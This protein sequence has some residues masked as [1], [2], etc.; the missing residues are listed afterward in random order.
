MPRG[1][2]SVS[3]AL[4]ALAIVLATI[5]TGAVAAAQPVD[6]PP[7]AAGPAADAVAATS[8]VVVRWSV[9]SLDAAT[10]ANRRAKLDDRGR[11][12]TLGVA[13]GR[14]AA[15][16]R[17]FGISGTTGVYRFEAPLGPN[18]NGVVR[19]LEAIPG[20]VTAEADPIVTIDALPNDP[21]AS[22]E[23]GDLGAA[24][25]SPYGID[26]VGAWG[27]STGEDTVVA[28][29]DTGIQAH[30]DLA[31]QTVAGYD[32]IADTFAAGDGDG[33]DADPTDPGDFVTPQESPGHCGVRNSSWHGTHVAGIA[34]AAANNAIGVFGAAP[35][36]KIQA[37]R[38]LGKCGG[39]FTDISDGLTWA[40]GGAVI[41]VPLNPT[42][43]DVANLSLGSGVPCPAF[44]QSAV[45]AARARGTL[46]VVSAGNA[47]VPAANH[48]PSNCAGVVAVAATDD[49]GK[50]SVFSGTTSSNYGSAVD[51]AAP[52]SNIPS[53]WNAGTMTPGTEAIGTGSGT[54]QAAPHVAAIAALLRAS[55]PEAQPAALERAL[56]SAVTAFGADATALGCPTLG[57]GAGIANAPAALAF[58]ATADI[59]A[60]TVTIT[61]PASPT[62]A[63]TLTFA[64]DF[65]E[66]ITGLTVS[67]LTVGGTASGCVIGPPTGSGDEWTVTLG[68][69]GNGT[70]TLT[71]GA[72][73]VED[74][75]ANVGP[76][77][78]ADSTS[79][80][81]DRA[82][83][84]SAGSIAAPATNGT[85][86]SVA[87]TA[88]DGSG[89]GISSVQAFYSTSASLTSPQAC[90]SV[91]SSAASGTITCTLPAVDATYRVY[92]RA[93]DGLGT[94]EAAPGA[95][96]DTIVRDTVRPGA[97]ITPGKP[98]SNTGS[99]TYTVT[100]TESVSGLAQDDLVLGGTA[101][102][103]ALQGF[104]AGASSATVNV[105]GCGNGIVTLAL[106]ADA[107]ADIAG[108]TGPEGQADAAVVVMDT[109]T[110]TIGVPTVT[111]RTGVPLKGSSIPV[112]V[113]WAGGD[114]AGGAGIAGYTLQRSLDGGSTWSTLASGLTSASRTTTVPS[115]GTTRFR[116]RATD[117]AGNTSSYATGGTRT[118]RLV[119]QSSSSVGYAGSWT[120][121]SSSKFSGGTVRHASTAG[122]AAAYTFTGKSI[123]VVSTRSTIRG[124][125]RI[126]LDGVLQATVD[127]Y[128]S[129]AEY[130]SVI[131]QQSFSS[132]VT[133]RVRIVVVGTGGRPRVDL[134]AF[135][136]IK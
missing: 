64:L 33:R 86:V 84:T 62:T 90:G 45:N 69:C 48:A 117:K 127:T 24:D 11:V 131:W 91:S 116:V 135:A 70:V 113:A 76:E 43:A 27:T 89:V 114:N 106:V 78:A 39:N 38:V 104:S 29:L 133:K 7:V 134:D 41:G 81:V 54:S 102:G 123:A 2:R 3:S 101:T 16:V 119:Q 92:T 99:V 122:R 129:P 1:A 126:Y 42:P 128:R 21:F 44:F 80:V 46:T 93:T 30:A 110:P 40:S 94:V 97:T 14:E 35:D 15:F 37:V 124:A 57:C 118:G 32:M 36:T 73:R 65:S 53:T 120:L 19:R 26:A 77:A 108:N 72:Q 17:A 5:G 75:V 96:D 34:G 74:L 105:V 112:T 59:E 71:L 50:R 87:Y 31:G 103:C 49:A 109:V 10:P 88:S 130:R 4:G 12:A 13:A 83:P 58:L 56:T 136:V 115:S 95:A 52:G 51:I 111:P 9:E 79:V 8:Q 22:I 125:V 66:A 20:V 18:A 63:A 107:A 61:P 55:E 121:A 98:A 100:F 85:S 23:W 82:A 67:D 25:G 28:I 132:V 60:P 68:G 6:L 47:G